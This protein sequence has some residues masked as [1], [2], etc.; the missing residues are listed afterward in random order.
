MSASEHEVH[1]LLEIEKQ[2]EPLAK[3]VEKGNLTLRSALKEAFHLGDS[4]GWTIHHP[5]FVDKEASEWEE[6]SL[7]LPEYEDPIIH[8]HYYSDDRNDEQR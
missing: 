8:H 3:S 1:I 5:G 2:I 6:W 4:V 7:S